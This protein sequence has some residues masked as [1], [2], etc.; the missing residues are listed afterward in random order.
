MECKWSEGRSGSGSRG[1]VPAAREREGEQRC[2]LASAG[3]GRG[4]ACYWDPPAVLDIL[5]NTWGN[6]LGKIC[7]ICL[8]D[9]VGVGKLDLPGH[10]GS[11]PAMQHPQRCPQKTPSQKRLC[12]AG[13]KRH[14]GSHRHSTQWNWVMRCPLPPPNP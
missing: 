8:A 7:L 4:S 6:G 14:K 9:P 3:T 13:K 10:F 5:D 11:R 2:F 12:E 1:W